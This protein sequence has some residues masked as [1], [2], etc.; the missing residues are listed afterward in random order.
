MNDAVGRAV[1]GIRLSSLAVT[2]TGCQVASNMVPRT[3]ARSVS[4]D[5]HHT[6]SVWRAP[7]IDPPDDHLFL[8]TRPTGATAD[9]SRNRRRLVQDDHLDIRQS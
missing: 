1:V 5:G 2:A 4:P 3:L 9:G 6:A 7:T 8:E